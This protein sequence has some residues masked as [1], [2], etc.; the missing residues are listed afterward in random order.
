MHHKFNL[1]FSY[2][3]LVKIEA[4]DFLGSENDICIETEGVCWKCSPTIT[5]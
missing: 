5:S 2:M 1:L 3:Y 4:D